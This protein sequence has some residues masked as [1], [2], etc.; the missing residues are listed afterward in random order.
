[1]IQRTWRG[2]VA[3]SGPAAAQR[4]RNSD[5]SAAAI[6]VQVTWYKRNRLF[7][8][9]VLMRSLVVQHEKDCHIDRSKQLST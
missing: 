6:R 3:R 2:Y 7:S 5:L 8:A 4:R 9:F 1:M